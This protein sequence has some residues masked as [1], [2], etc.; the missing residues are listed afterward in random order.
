MRR[1]L[2]NA[3]IVSMNSA[4]DLF[5]GSVVI[6]DGAIR[7]VL[8]E[9]Q[10]LPEAEQI[11]NLRGHALLPGFV[12]SHLHCCQTL[13]RGL[14]DD[15]SLLDWLKDRIWPLEAA[16][17]PD[18]LAAAAR[19]TVLELL[20][21]GTTAI[22]SMETVRH[23]QRVF[24]T[25]APLPVRAQIGKCLMNQ[26]CDVPDSLIE[27]GEQGLHEALRLAGLY[28]NVAGARLRA[29]LAPRFALCCSDGLLREL[30]SEAERFDLLI[31]T[32]GA[33]QIEEVERIRESC[34]LGNLEYLHSLGL[35]SPRL[36]LAHAVHLDPAEHDLLKSS[37]AQV[38]HCPASNLKLGSGVAPIARYLELGVPVSVG[39][40]GAACNNNLD[41][42]REARL[43]ALLQK[44]LCGPAALPA[45]QALELI[46]ISGA[47]ALGME[48]EI[49]SIESGKRADLVEID[50]ERAHTIPSGDP[51]SRIIYAA[52]RADI[53]RVYFDGEVV[54]E[55]GEALFCDAEEVRADAV[56]ASRDLIV[57]AGLA[58]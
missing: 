56:R 45:R 20:Q 24:E 51:Y 42:L 22:L 38:L 47:R 14:A 3:C 32:H 4:G 1:I 17:D 8:R 44:P 21:G 48:A 36:R 37:G 5:R 43:A 2:T 16:H 53:V 41:A 55:N 7:K 39:A 30:A 18:S 19:L 33:E 31:H 54:V 15:L 46:T 23:T 35:A 49:G 58:C 12:Q 40:D 50:L 10:P 26:G 6:E 27:S 11:I 57:R 9:D 29:C 13:F 28:P 25:L 34:G 52:E